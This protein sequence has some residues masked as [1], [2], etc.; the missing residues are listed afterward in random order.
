[1]S[2][3]IALL[4]TLRGVVHSRAVLHLEVLALRHQV[5]VLQTL[6]TATLSS[7][8]RGPVALGVIVTRLARLANGDPRRERATVSAGEPERRHLRQLGA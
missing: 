8:P 6:A 2:M 7:R 4:A 1:M 3:L 5:Q